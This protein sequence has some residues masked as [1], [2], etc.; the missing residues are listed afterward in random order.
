[1]CQEKPALQRAAG[2]QARKEKKKNKERQ[3]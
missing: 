1:M 3:D 2:K